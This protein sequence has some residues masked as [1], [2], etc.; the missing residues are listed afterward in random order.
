MFT[1]GIHEYDRAVLKQ[2]EASN[3]IRK[4]NYVNDVTNQQIT[5]RCNMGSEHTQRP[6]DVT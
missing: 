5:Y 2:R 1:S 6:N 4:H 3:D